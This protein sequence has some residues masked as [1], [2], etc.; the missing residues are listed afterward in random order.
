MEERRYSGLFTAMLFAVGLGLGGVITD[1]YYCRNPDHPKR[2]E[3]NGKEY[4]KTGDNYLRL[5][6]DSTY[7][8]IRGKEK[9]SLKNKI[10]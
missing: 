4:L 8:L 1:Y 6:K 5:E 7:S 3:L 2:I 9:K 10:K